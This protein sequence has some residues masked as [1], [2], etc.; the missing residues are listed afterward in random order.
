MH[1]SRQSSELGNSHFSKIPMRRIIKLRQPCR[2]ARV[3]WWDV[4]HHPLPGAGKQHSVRV[5][6]IALSYIVFD[7]AP[8]LAMEFMRQ[9]AVVA[10][11]QIAIPGDAGPVE[12]QTLYL[13]F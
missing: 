6:Q 2:I 8:P 10:K 4:N 3:A 11:P 9:P 7:F 1:R 13:K 5:A 12:F